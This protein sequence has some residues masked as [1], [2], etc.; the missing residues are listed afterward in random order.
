MPVNIHYIFPVHANK[1]T[2]QI[3]K[4]VLTALLL[5][6]SGLC[7]GEIVTAENGTTVFNT[8]PILSLEASGLSE[9]KQAEKISAWLVEIETAI[10]SDGESIPA[11][12]ALDL[13]ER[14]ILRLSK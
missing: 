12:I 10:A 4:S 11:R 8:A 5:G 3:M 9:V 7:A 13:I 1:G 6:V 14:E 2:F